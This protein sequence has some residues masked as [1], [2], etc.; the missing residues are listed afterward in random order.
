[1]SMGPKIALEAAKIIAV[2]VATFGAGAW[3]IWF[4]VMWIVS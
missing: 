1:M 4:V 3:I 2:L